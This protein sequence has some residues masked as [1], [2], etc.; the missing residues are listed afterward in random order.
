M[1]KITQYRLPQDDRPYDGRVNLFLAGFKQQ[2]IMSVDEIVHVIKRIPDAHLQGLKEL[3]YD[4]ERKTL[5]DIDYQQWQL[6]SQS[7]ASFVQQRQHIVIYEF[8]NKP[9]FHQILCHEIGHYVFYF[10]IGSV[11]KKQWVTELYP[12]SEHIT[13]YASRNASEDFAESYAAY[14][15]QPDELRRL[16]PKK[17]TFLL[18]KVF[19]GYRPEK[20]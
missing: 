12:G 5:E 17:H 7:K 20:I 19:K 6:L 18:S 10:I 11:L 9:L 8:D 2:D 3:I 14:L 16:L 1:V 15:I 4:P 13:E